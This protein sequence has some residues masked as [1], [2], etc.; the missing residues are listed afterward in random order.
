MQKYRVLKQYP[1]QITNSGR[2]ITLKPGTLVYLK[3]EAQV[4]R[5]VQLGFIQSVIELPV[6][7]KP[8][9]MLTPD[10]ENQP[11]QESEDKRKSKSD[12]LN[13]K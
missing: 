10:I 11:S 13:K 12:Y 1:K 4:L 8:T 9:P 3:K 2:L 5:L 7:S 6:K